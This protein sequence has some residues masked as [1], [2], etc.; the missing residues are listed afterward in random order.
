MAY[1]DHGDGKQ[2]P[3]AVSVS[4]FVP[5]CEVGRGTHNKAGSRCMVCT[6]GCPIVAAADRLAVEEK[7]F[8][9]MQRSCGDDESF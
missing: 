1:H 6:T 7:M 8:A 4:V 3:P 5:N 9:W 2:N